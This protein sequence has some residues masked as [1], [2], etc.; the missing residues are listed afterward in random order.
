MEITSTCIFA[1]I[2]EC[3]AVVFREDADGLS[4]DAIEAHRQGSQV[5]QVEDTHR[6]FLNVGE[7]I[8]PVLFQRNG[9]YYMI[10]AN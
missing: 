1:Q 3:D 9:E 10:A 8:F 4:A 2:G 7:G 6:A 5:I